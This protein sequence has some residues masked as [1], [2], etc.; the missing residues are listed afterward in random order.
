[1]RTT[2]LTLYLDHTTFNTMQ[3]TATQAATHCGVALCTITKWAREHRI[4][5]TGT[6]NAGRKLYRLA[7][8][9]TV[10]REGRRFG[11]ALYLLRAGSD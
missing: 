9:V 5:P 7:D 4:T 1:M 3:V 10:E 6:N 11:Y 2:D 8:I